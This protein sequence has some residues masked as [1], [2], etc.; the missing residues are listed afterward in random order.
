MDGHVQLV[1][2][3]HHGVPLA[4]ACH[5]GRDAVLQLLAVADAHGDPVDETA[6]GVEASASSKS[7][8]ISGPVAARATTVNFVV[9][10][11]PR[12]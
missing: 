7:R 8:K 1:Q 10:I 12:P 2:D 11:A 3:G 4:S 9:V 5:R 6:Q